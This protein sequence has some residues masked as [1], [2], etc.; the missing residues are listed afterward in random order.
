[1]KLE[2]NG[3]K[4]DVSEECLLLQSERESQARIQ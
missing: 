1:M 2:E 4:V 3:R